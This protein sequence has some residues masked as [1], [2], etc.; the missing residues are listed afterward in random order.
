M[1]TKT[2]LEKTRDKEMTA[3]QGQVKT[4]FDLLNS[5]ES[6]K[7]IAQGAPKYLNSDAL[8][9]V[10]L[11]AVQKNDK[12]MQCSAGSI[13]QACM[14][15]AAY[16]LIPSSATGEAHLVPFGKSVVLVV[17]YLGLI[18]MA[19]NSGL[20]SGVTVR[21]VYENDHFDHELGLNEKLVHKPILTGERGKFIGAYAVVVKNDGSKTP[22]YL[23]MEEGLAHGKKFSKTFANGPWKSDPEAMVCKTVVKMSLK[24]EAKSAEDHRL[25][26]AMLNDDK[27]EAG[28]FNIGMPHIH[29]DEIKDPE[30]IDVEST[31][32]KGDN[33]DPATGEVIPDEL[34]AKGSES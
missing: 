8:I 21:K 33:I 16:G 17:G 24:Y 30:P 3:K 19:Q 31:E 11:T 32:K 15:C 12:L 26:R 20:V 34:F 29:D 9:R 14:D 1:T 10:A 18:K 27:M 13:L 2:N 25:T 28:D 22:Y 23:T 6:K 4:I 7:K 5:D